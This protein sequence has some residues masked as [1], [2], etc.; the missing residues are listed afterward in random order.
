MQTEVIKQVFLEGKD[1][2]SSCHERG[3]KNKIL[4]PCE[5]SNLRP[6]DSALRRSTTELQ[7]LYGKQGPLRGSYMARVQYTAWISNVVFVNRVREMK[8]HLS[9]SF[10]FFL[11][12]LPLLPKDI[13]QPQRYDALAERL[14]KYISQN[15]N[16]LSLS[17]S[18]ALLN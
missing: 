8:K 3:T 5:E 17:F 9:L 4:T 18:V 7:R 15:T 14:F 13:F 6:S 11:I 2:F 1:V 16:G 12:S 10:L